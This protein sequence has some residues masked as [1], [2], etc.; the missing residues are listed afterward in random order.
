MNSLSFQNS[1][2]K[3]N[4][5]SDTMNEIDLEKVLNYPVYPRDSR[6]YSDKKFVNIDDGGMGGT[7]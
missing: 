3:F 2:K 6:I 1:M 7:H 4:L 5:R